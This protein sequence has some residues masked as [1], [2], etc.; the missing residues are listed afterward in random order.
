MFLELSTEEK[1][2][3]F[4]EH[5]LETNRGFSYFVDWANVYI[6]EE[7]KIEMR[8][9][10]VLIRINEEGRFRET[11]FSLLRRIPSVVSIFPILFALAKE[12]RKNLQ[13]PNKK[14]SF[15]LNG[16]DDD[17]SISCSFYKGN[18]GFSDEEIGNYY[19][20]F[21]KMGLKYLYQN[22]IEKSTIDYVYGVLVGMDSNGRKNRGGK[23]FELACLPIFERI[24]QEKGLK[25]L[26]Q[27]KFKE[28][29]NYGFEIVG[30]MEN[31]IADFIV[32]SSELHK[33][34]NFEVNFFN[35]TGSKPEEI[36][37]SYINRQ[38]SLAYYG[39][40]FSLIT[41]GINCWK[42][43]KN[44][45]TKGFSHLYYLQNYYMFKHGMLEE[46]LDVVFPQ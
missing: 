14:L 34:I 36:I 10:D 19:V 17:D 41:D 24:T 32:V 38:A 12:E 26:F 16:I 4:S 43:A 27:K 21:T 42:N 39:I 29:N 35:N 9:L 11:F 28:L 45:I 7:Y 18:A 40:D 22:I 5:L 1:Y 25:L 6:S 3:Y 30:D 23:V 33:A 44:Q 46:I 15:I 2:H 13:K 8:A 37:D 31:R 20:F